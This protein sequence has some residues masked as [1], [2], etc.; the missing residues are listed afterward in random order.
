MLSK[1]YRLSKKKDFDGVF[2]K[3]ESI[4]NGFLIF[5]VLNN[6]SNSSGQ[7]PISRFGF[8]V[9]KKISTKATVRNKV[10]RRL[11]DAVSAKLPELKKSKDV[12]V[13]TLPGIEKKEFA[14]IEK[15]V[16][17]SLAKLKLI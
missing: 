7:V 1:E 4:K 17:D 5:K 8:V 10:K 14:E 13:I 2:K 15:M 12:I 3:G 11:R 16:A 6:P 9:S